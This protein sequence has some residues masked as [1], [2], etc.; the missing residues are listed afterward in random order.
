[1]FAETP[2]SQW[3]SRESVV[4][5]FDRYFQTG[6]VLGALSGHSLRHSCAYRLVGFAL[7]QPLASAFIIGQSTWIKPE[8]R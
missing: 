7:V 6:S 5:M 8:E 1:M 2:L 3:W 4:A